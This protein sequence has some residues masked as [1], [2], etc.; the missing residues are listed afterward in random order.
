MDHVGLK[1]VLHGQREVPA[2]SQ[3]DRLDA[4]V[5][6]RA[7]QVGEE[8]L[9]GAHAAGIKDSACAAALASRLLNQVC[10][11]S[12]K[13]SHRVHLPDD[14]TACTQLGAQQREAP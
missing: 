9:Q 4:A 12:S 13:A 1:L 11:M 10:T 6:I 8:H 3:D 5:D 7:A 2:H 14:C